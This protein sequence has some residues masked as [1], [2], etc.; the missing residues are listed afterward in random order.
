MGK[1]R[2][3]PRKKRSTQTGRKVLSGAELSVGREARY[4]V[5]CARHLDARVVTLGR[6]I[7]FST[8]NGDAWVLDFD[9][10]LALCLA[11]EGEAQPYRIVE[12]DT[13]F[14]IEWNAKYAITQDGFV[15]EDDT[16]RLRLF[17]GYPVEHI[18]EAEKR[19][20]KWS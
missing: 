4:I 9:D 17:P 5:D 18:I 16:G 1:R 6:L 19:T 7:F 11:L 14:A 10:R 3:K 13:R 2:K 8:D 12:T 20:R 15:V